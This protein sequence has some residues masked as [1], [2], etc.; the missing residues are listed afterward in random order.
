MSPSLMSARINPNIMDRPEKEWDAFISHAVEDQ[1]SFVRNLTTLLKRLGLKVWYAETALQVGDSLSASINKG[2]ANSQYGIVVISP[3]FIAK[4]WPNW[5]L[6]G[7]VNR[8]N[9][10]EQ[11]VILPIWHRV[12]KQDVMDF[13]P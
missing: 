3:H 10:E 9:S 4:K 7:L 12:T 11:N 13:S 1:G 8:Q 6:A 5:E 2:L